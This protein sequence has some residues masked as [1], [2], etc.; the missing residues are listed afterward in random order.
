MLRHNACYALMP[1]LAEIPYLKP[2]NGNLHLHSPKKS[3]VSETQDLPHA[4]TIN[5]NDRGR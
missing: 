4:C 1:P 2:V 5:Y 3:E